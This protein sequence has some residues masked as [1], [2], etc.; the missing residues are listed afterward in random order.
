[1]DQCILLT[2]GFIRLTERYK[3]SQF[4]FAAEH[5]RHNNP[6]AYIIAVGHGLK[7]TKLD[8]YCDH[9][10]WQPQILESEINM[11]HPIMVNR[12]IFRIK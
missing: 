2:H 9:I 12:G 3:I 7:P 10:D 11:G 1:M 8:T 5:F 6:D 4:N